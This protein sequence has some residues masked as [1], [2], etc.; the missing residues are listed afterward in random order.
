[1]DFK[2]NNFFANRVIS[3]PTAA[4]PSANPVSTPEPTNNLNTSFDA[5]NAEGSGGGKGFGEDL[6]SISLKSA[7]GIALL[8][9]I[10]FAMLGLDFSGSKRSSRGLQETSESYYDENREE[11]KSMGISKRDVNEYK[12]KRGLLNGL[13]CDGYKKSFFC[14]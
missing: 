12:S 10:I 14:K 4:A 1:M 7:G 6:K 11:L 13:F 2:S 8:I 3:T 9:L 5:P